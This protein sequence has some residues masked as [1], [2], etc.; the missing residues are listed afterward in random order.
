MMTASA[1]QRIDVEELLAIQGHARQDPVVRHAF[2][3]VG[4]LGVGV[5]QV[6]PMGPEG[7]ANG[8]ARLAIGRVVGQFIG[9]A[10]RLAGMARADAAGHI[11]L[12]MH[13]VV[14]QPAHGG[15]QRLVAAVRRHVGHAAIQIHG[16]HRMPYDLALLAHGHVVLVIRPPYLAF[17]LVAANVDEELGQVQILLLAG[18][19]VQLDQGQFDFL[20]ARHFLPLAR[21]ERGLDMIGQLHGHVEELAFPGGAVGERPRLR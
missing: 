13:H 6:Q 17:R 15:H 5:Q 14:P 19:L 8:R 12:V 7:Q 11:H 18:H 9:I 3:H 16:A 10:E 2:Q 4:I 21:P 1:G 20:V